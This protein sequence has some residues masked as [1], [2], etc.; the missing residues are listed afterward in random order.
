MLINHRSFTVFFS[1]RVINLTVLAS[2]ESTDGWSSAS[3]R[4]NCES[5]YCAVTQSAT[6]YWNIEAMSLINWF[7]SLGSRPTFLLFC[8]YVCKFVI[9][10]KK[11]LAK[12]QGKN[13]SESVC[14][15]I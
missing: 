3:G 10:E 13:L 6:Y 12:Q 7:S 9:I 4:R 1:Q 2:V 15:G 14:T 8:H 5:I 11:L